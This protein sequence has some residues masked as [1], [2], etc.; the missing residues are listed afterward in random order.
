VEGDGWQR[1]QRMGDDGTMEGVQWLQVV[2]GDWITTAMHVIE[3][4]K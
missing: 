4:G 3:W 2:E 1:Q